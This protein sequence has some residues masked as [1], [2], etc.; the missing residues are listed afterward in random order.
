MIRVLYG[1]KDDLVSANDADRG[2]ACHCT[3]PGCG[4]ALLA[5]KGTRNRPHFAHAPGEETRRF[6]ESALHY[7]AKN[8]MA[9]PKAG[10]G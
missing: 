4:G 10:E 1:L 3:Y 7:A 6:G 8:L 2:A 5:R 9:V